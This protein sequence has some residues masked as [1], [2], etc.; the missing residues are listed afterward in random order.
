MPISA[1]SLSFPRTFRPF[2]LSVLVAA[3]SACGGGGS[4]SSADTGGSAGTA[5]DIAALAGTYTLAT[6]ST[7]LGA[8][9]L[10]TQA[11]VTTCTLKSQSACSV[12]FIPPAKSGD[13][14]IFSLQGDEKGTT[15]K[16][17]ISPS[18]SV[19]GQFSQSG[20]ADTSLTGSKTSNNY[21]S[22]DEPFTRTGGKCVPP[23]S[24]V[25]ALVPLIKWNQQI[26]PVSYTMILCYPS[27]NDCIDI[28]QRIVLTA[29]D[30][31]DD[32]TP[33][34]MEYAN[35]VAAEFQKMLVRLRDAGSP[36]PTQAQIVRIFSNAV[37]SAI[38]TETPNAVET[39][40]EAFKKAG[41]PAAADGQGGS[42]GQK[43]LSA[44]D[45]CSQE[46]YRGDTSEPQVYL[47]DKL[48]QF[49]RCLFKAT[50]D[51]SFLKDGNGQCKVLDGL[52]AATIG[53]FKPQFCT[54][55][56]LK[57]LEPLE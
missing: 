41:F 13:S 38:E 35:S 44:E 55:P 31:A 11:T 10:D 12:E 28:S 14:A 27:S 32:E 4:D 6:G 56:T 18:G 52:L 2:V 53:T 36:H 48:A 30:L 46:D 8:F 24:G 42:A 43:P 29:E 1:V 20:Q 17:V 51:S 57:P 45:A 7:P 54:G 49:D 15:A 25:K 21:A 5:P 9:M 22:C 16:G 47:F 33:P 39:A 34:I 37:N 40:I 26:N 3:M 23:V 19:T 50:G